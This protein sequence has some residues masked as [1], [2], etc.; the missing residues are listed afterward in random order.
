MSF[1]A[2]QSHPLAEYFESE[3]SALKKERKLGISS[4][5]KSSGLM[6]VPVPWAGSAGSCQKSEI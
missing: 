5:V 4:S 6:Q 2:S 1:D 3:I